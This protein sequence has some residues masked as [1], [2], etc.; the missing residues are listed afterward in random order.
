MV[1]EGI[2]VVELYCLGPRRMDSTHHLLTEG[3]GSSSKTQLEIIVGWKLEFQ[4]PFF[5]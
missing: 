2:A 1:N 4:L 3:K 5:I